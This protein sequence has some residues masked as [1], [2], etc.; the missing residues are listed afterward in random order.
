M[1]E[2]SRDRVIKVAL[3]VVWLFLLIECAFLFWGFAITDNS[4]DLEIGNAITQTC[5]VT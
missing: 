3:V 4:T 2:V 5:G 1:G